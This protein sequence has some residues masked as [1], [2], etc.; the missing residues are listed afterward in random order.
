MGKA[1]YQLSNIENDYQ[2]YIVPTIEK[3]ESE[4]YEI[5]IKWRTLGKEVGI[6]DDELDAF[7]K[8]WTDPVK[9]LAKVLEFWKCGKGTI[10]FSW[11]SVVGILKSGSMLEWEKAENLQKF[12]VSGKLIRR[13]FRKSESI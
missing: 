10:P 6:P 5:R 7:N 9:L 2:F 12:L 8:Q 1:C 4:L 3:M 11:A 13:K